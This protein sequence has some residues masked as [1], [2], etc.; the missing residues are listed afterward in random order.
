MGNH[1]PMRSNE[2]ADAKTAAKPAKP[3]RE[4]KPLMQRLDEQLTR[5]AVAKKV[6]HE[7]LAKLET[8]VGRL[9]AFLEE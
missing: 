9:K 3:K 6:T 4:P 7:E 2:M 8:R 5:A 1:V